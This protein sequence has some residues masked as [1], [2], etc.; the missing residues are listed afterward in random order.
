MQRWAVRAARWL[1]LIW[2][3]LFLSASLMHP[4]T[5]SPIHG[6]GGDCLVCTLQ[7]NPAPEPI[8]LPAL[9]QPINNPTTD[10]TI[11]PHLE[12]AHD[13]FLI[14]IKTPRAPPA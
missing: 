4:L 2:A 12:R 3:T 8:A 9:L 14:Q 10:L 11:P 1:S 7:K 5:H 13:T 6:S